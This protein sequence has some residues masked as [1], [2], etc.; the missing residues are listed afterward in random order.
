[1]KFYVR[2]QYRDIHLDVYDLPSFDMRGA[3]YDMHYIGVELGRTGLLV[4]K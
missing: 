2:K 1:M 4:V 3:A